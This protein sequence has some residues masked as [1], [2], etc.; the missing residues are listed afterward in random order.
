MGILLGIVMVVYIC[1]N[2]DHA[3]IMFM[4]II[5]LHHLRRCP[6]QLTKKYFKFINKGECYKFTVDESENIK[7]KDITSEVVNK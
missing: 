4:V 5:I 1:M 6:F 3:G 2:I 7:W